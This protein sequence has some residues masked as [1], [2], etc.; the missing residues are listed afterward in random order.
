VK[1]FTLDITCPNCGSEVEP[2][3]WVRRSPT[4]TWAEVWCAEC[5]IVWRVD[6]GVTMVD[7]IR[8]TDDPRARAGAAL[9]E[10]VL[11]VLN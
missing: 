3:E 7:A 9:G 1:H 5:L 6:A 2:R 4:L 10:D 11:S 8:T